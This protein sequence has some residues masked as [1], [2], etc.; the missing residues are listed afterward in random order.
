MIRSVAIIA[1]IGE[2]PD[3]MPFAQVMRSGRYP[4]RSAANVWPSRPKAQITSSET[5]RTSYRSQISRTR[6]K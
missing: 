5:S 4:Y 1:P 6:W 3:V 2:Y